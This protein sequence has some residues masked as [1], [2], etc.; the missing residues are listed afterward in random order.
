[1][2]AVGSGNSKC[3]HVPWKK[4][5]VLQVEH[6]NYVHRISVCISHFQVVYQLFSSHQKSKFCGTVLTVLALG[7]FKHVSTRLKPAKCPTEAPFPNVPR[8]VI[9]TLEL[10]LVDQL[11]LVGHWRTTTWDAWSVGLGFGTGRGAQGSEKGLFFGW[12]SVPKTGEDKSH[13][14]WLMECN[15][16]KICICWFQL[17]FLGQMNHK[18]GVYGPST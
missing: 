15:L 3:W 7:Y 13:L 14:M 8:S 4:F 16:V 6:N 17:V 10:S 18:N 5:N 12:R 9:S 11:H 2:K 1:M